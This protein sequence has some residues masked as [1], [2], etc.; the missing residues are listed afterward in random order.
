MN[1]L[2][3]T[4]FDM[5]RQPLVTWLTICGTALSLFLM[6]SIYMVDQFSSVEVAPESR[7]SRIWNSPYIHVEQTDGQGSSS[8]SM[9]KSTAR[10]L[11]EGLPGVEMISY[12]DTWNQPLDVDY[13]NGSIFSME[14]RKVDRNFWK[15]FD[16][17]FKAGRPFTEAEVSSGAKKV[18]LTDVSAAK[19]AG[20]RDL[21]GKEIMVARVPHQVVGI[22]KATSPLLTQTY[23]EIYLPYKEDPDDIW[24]TYMGS[25]GVIL[26]LSDDADPSVM[27]KEVQRR[28]EQFNREIAKDNLRA[29]YHQAPF[30]NEKP[31]GSNTDPSDNRFER[32]ALY[33]ILLLL[34]AINLSGMTRSRLKR[35]VA[36]IG[37][38]RSFGATKRRI[39]GQLLG[40][41]LA[42][43]VIG[44]VIGL[45]LSALFV[46]FFFNAFFDYY[47]W[48]VTAAKVDV[49]PALN[50]VFTWR[51]FG[52]ALLFCFVLNILSAGIPA[53]KASR[54]NPAEAMK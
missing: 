52:F 18:I 17:E 21:L 29:I 32:Y 22:V 35:R 6:L 31:G 28:Y 1:I 23:G 2:K 34:P 27:K 33:A 44:G 30:H 45:I 8:G 50:M 41:N 24:S 54:E 39:I 3:Q 53:W 15:M 38:R 7:R 49:S 46:I 42:I 36:E 37:L 26:L 14:S 4:W 51:V 10:K 43:T 16:F 48:D 40:E 47:G 25:T 11:Y 9:S 5:N 20:N 19:L 12:Q 13:Q